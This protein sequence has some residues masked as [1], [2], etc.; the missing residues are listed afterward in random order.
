MKKVLLFFIVLT[1]IKLE[2]QPILVN[3]SPYANVSTI[4]YDSINNKI[5]YNFLYGCQ[6]WN[7]PCAYNYISAYKNLV[8]KHSYFDNTVSTVLSSSFQIGPPNYP[9]NNANSAA[10]RQM[11]CENGS[12]YNNFGFYFNKIDTTGLAT[13][14]SYSP[15]VNPSY[16]EVS[17]F[18]IKNDSVFF[19]EKDS[20]SGNNYYTLFLK[21]KLTGG[22]IPYNSIATTNPANSLGAIEGHVNNSLLIN[23]SIILSG[24]FTASISGALVARNLVS[25]NLATGQLQVPTVT[26][27]I[28]TSILDMIINNNKI[29]LA[30]QFTMINGQTRNNYAVLDLNLNLLAENLQFTGWVDPP[31]ATWVDK[32]IFYDKYLIAKG[33][34]ASIGPALFSFTNTYA[35]RVVNIENNNAIMPWTLTLPGTPVKSEYTFQMIKNKL[36]IKNRPSFGSPFYIYCF[37]P[38]LNAANILFPGS[39]LANPIPSIAICSPDNGNANI[40]VAPIRYASV[41]N[42]TYSGANATLVP[43]GN[44][45]TAKLIISTI[46][47]N[48]LLSVIG[49][50]DCGLSTIAATLNVVINPKPTFTLPGSPQIIICN[51]DSTLV[52]GTT[53]NTNSTIWWRKAGT[54]TINPQPFYSKTP[55]NYFMVILD[56]TNG[57]KDSGAVMV[58]NMK[59]LPNSKIISHIYP[60]VIIPID[61]VT[62]YKP[63]VNIIAA[64]DTAG[65]TITWKSIN[66]NSVFPNP[67][68]ISLQNNLKIIVNR[69]NNNCVD[70]SIIV[71]VAQDNIKP[72]IT[73]N[74]LNQTINC[75]NYT[76]GLTA[77]FSPSSSSSLWTGP[78][79]YTVS[80]PGSTTIPGKYFIKVKNQGNG[81]AQWDSLFVI[82]N[83]NLVLMSSN[84]TTV[85]KQSPA[86]LKS[87]RIGTLAGITY[88]WSSG[89]LINL[90][91]V[92]PSVTTNYIVYANGAGGC[93]GTDTIKVNVPSDI[94]D[95]VLTFRSCDNSQ[96][97][98]IVMFAKGGIP[99]Y[100]YSINNG[101][102]F[103]SANSFTNLP[104]GNYNLIIK[105]SISCTKSSSVT[106]NNTSNLPVPK[107]LASTKNYKSDTIVLVDISLPK[108]DSIRWLLPPQ[109][110]K[111]GGNMF[112]PII[113][114]SDT[115]SFLITMRSFYGTCII[116]TVKLLRFFQTD[117]VHATY[118]NANGIKSFSLFPNP[119]TGQFTVIIEFY[120]KQNASVQAWDTSPY[121][122]L[123]QNF[124][125]V[126]II[127][128]PV[129][130]SQLQNGQYIMRVIGEYDAKNKPFIISK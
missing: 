38:V 24:V 87:I 102:S 44:G 49:S 65:V 43:Q 89:S 103:L 19:F 67:L 30:G 51:P 42:W 105:D 127:N 58:N 63:L 29:Y 27:N 90:A 88:S 12:I 60:G 122:Y 115:G 93:F 68:T 17:T 79:N 85:C 47:T 73:V 35:A 57:C 121:N 129:N 76:V 8:N 74:N 23:N 123:Q 37:E 114:I 82:A 126:E 72:N 1:Y 4:A 7:I 59:A 62:C 33:N 120:K 28:G 64:S 55:G 86:I 15:A 80:N 13:I 94:Q 112:N 41:Y 26:F 14:W 83:N 92:N 40:F 128:M 109:A 108:A 104:Y 45:S 32:I 107:F 2:A 10:A 81:C 113:T 5:F 50:N 106:L 110:L 101:I 34:F 125:D 25:I 84:D 31:S 11:V 46:S 118:N 98:S 52:Q 18:Q 71:F 99:P 117:S 69:N 77:A 75:S 91:I 61:T 16:K 130:L 20:I 53:T 3:T 78:A 54:S 48:G 39:T 56:N 119:N 111:I 9:V 97:G 100:K 95:S 116:N 124:Y 6:Y 21:N 22:T 66:N 36:Y 96:T 70:S